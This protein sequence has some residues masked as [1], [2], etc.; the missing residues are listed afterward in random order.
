VGETLTVSSPVWSLPAVVTTYQWQRNGTDIPGAI[1]TTYAVL[2]A[3]VG[4]A[5]IAK[6]TGTK[7]GYTPANATTSPVTVLQ[8]DALTATS[9]PSIV[10]TGRIGEQLVAN[11]GAWGTPEPGFAYQWLR[12]GVAIPGAT[13]ATY[14]VLAG[15]A[16]HSLSFAVT[17]TRAGYTPGSATSAAVPIAK[18][19]STS[20][21]SLVAKKIKKGAHGMLRVVLGA[22][23]AK[24]SGMVQVY[25]GARLLK[26]YSM[27]I[28]DNGVRIV[29]LPVL[30]PGKHRIKAVYAGSASVL[31]ST[32]NVVTLKVVKKK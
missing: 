22:T 20:H 25:D 9:P 5:L 6:A 14:T 13:T 15:D 23:G 27:R 18:L 19:A 31:G 30:T 2:P 16:T 10:G 17:A 21:V 32:S 26:G 7:L 3:D 24:P 8:G 28:T 11:P 29:K 1:G 12:D 4:A